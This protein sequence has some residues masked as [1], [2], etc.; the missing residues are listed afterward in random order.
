MRYLV[1]ITGQKRSGKDTIA[2][3]MMMQDKLL[4]KYALADP[5]KEVAAKFFDW[6]LDSMYNDDIKEE[7]DPYWGIS[8]RQATQFIGTEVGRVGFANAYPMFDEV[9]E[10]RI[11]I[12]KFELKLHNLPARLNMVVPDIR[13][14]NE[15]NSLSKIKKE[16]NETILHETNVYEYDNE[17]FRFV[18]IGVRRPKTVSDNHASES[19]IPGLIEQCEYQIDNDGSIDSLKDKVKNIMKME[20]MSVYE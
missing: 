15:F 5:V 13:F 9:T 7:V 10:D 6:S 18:S 4:I 20:G 14:Q 12:K 2:Q 17:F 11:W 3:L 1:G 19:E 16:Y 8:R